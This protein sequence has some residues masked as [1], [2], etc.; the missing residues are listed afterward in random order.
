[1]P[2]PLSS[3][4]QCRVESSDGFPGLVQEEPASA[5]VDKKPTRIPVTEKPRTVDFIDVVNCALC[6]TESILALPIELEHRICLCELGTYPC[7]CGRR[8]A[9]RHRRS[10]SEYPQANDYVTVRADQ[11]RRIR[12]QVASEYPIH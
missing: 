1:V 10:V 4:A 5:F 9:I 7:P 12:P 6:A 3:C 8:Q 2:V 11:R